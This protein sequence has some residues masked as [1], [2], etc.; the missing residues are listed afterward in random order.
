MDKLLSEMTM[1]DDRRARFRTCLALI[2]SGE[3][4]VFEGIVDGLIT[5]EKRGKGG[6]GYDPIFLPDGE[7]APLRR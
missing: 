7:G 2:I 1:A 4:F 5:H 6:F 3:A